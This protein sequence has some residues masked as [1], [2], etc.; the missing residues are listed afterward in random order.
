MASSTN[1]ISALM[2]SGWRIDYQFVTRNYSGVRMNYECPLSFIVMKVCGM[3]RNGL[4]R[5]WTRGG[6]PKKGVRVL[7]RLVVCV[8]GKRLSKSCSLFKLNASKKARLLNERGRVDALTLSLEGGEK[9]LRCG[10]SLKTAYSDEKGTLVQ[11][12]LL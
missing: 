1:I 12:T 8:S 6:G 7:P 10:K 5:F 2:A 4:W 11:R 9:N 3:Y